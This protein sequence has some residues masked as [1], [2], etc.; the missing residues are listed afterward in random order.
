M[1]AF[2]T[3]DETELKYGTSN[4][5]QVALKSAADINGETLFVSITRGYIDGNG[6]KRYKTNVTLPANR[7]VIQRTIDALTGLLDLQ[8]ERFA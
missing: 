6:S 2:R 4:F 5:V 3:I 1:T 8:G 7:Q